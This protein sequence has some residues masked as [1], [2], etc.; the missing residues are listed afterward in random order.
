[1]RIRRNLMRLLCLV[2]ALPVVGSAAEGGSRSVVF[3]GSGGVEGLSFV[4]P[5]GIGLHVGE[6]PP[7]GKGRAVGCSRDQWE[8]QQA[9]ARSLLAAG[10]PSS[11]IARQVAA[12]LA[13]S[14]GLDSP[15]EPG[16]VGEPAKGSSFVPPRQSASETPQSNGFHPSWSDARPTLA[17]SVS[18]AARNAARMLERLIESREAGRQADDARARIDRDVRRSRFAAE[19]K[20]G[21]AELEGFS[22]GLS[23]GL[24][25]ARLDHDARFA[26]WSVEAKETGRRWEAE[27]AARDAQIKQDLMALASGAGGTG[28]GAKQGANS[29]ISPPASPAVVPPT[30]AGAAKGRPQTISPSSDA[31]PISSVVGTVGQPLPVGKRV[32]DRPAGPLTPEKCL[33]RIGP[34]S[35]PGEHTFDAILRNTFGSCCGGTNRCEHVPAEC[36]GTDQNASCARHDRDVYKCG[37]GAF[38]LGNACVRSAHRRLARDSSNLPF[39][40]IFGHL[41]DEPDLLPRIRDFYP[42]VGAPL[43]P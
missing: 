24:A 29:S 11:V 33:P 15:I 36:F 25:G 3:H 22:T 5:G 2:S 38:D 16:I 31:V 10:V 40:V 32:Y 20:A 18:D 9:L 12:N 27:H 13:A 21:R 34:E 4:G 41:G 30:G 6:S 28:S 37:S 14:D 23:Q 26:A 42:F 1:M 39:K 43:L 35:F 8:A 17:P 19:A 7:A